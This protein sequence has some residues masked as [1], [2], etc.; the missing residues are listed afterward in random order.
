VLTFPVD[1]VKSRGKHANRT[2][3][4]LT[5]VKLD[6]LIETYQTVDVAEECRHAL[7]WIQANPSRRKTYDG[8]AAF[9]VNWLNRAVNMRRS[10]SSVITGSLKTAGN[11]AALASFLKRHTDALDE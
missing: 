10:G 7:A 3:W 5:T 9:V 2:T 8:M 6:E 1:G 4:P 11:K